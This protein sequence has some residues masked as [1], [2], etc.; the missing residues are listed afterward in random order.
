MI[1]EKPVDE[2]EL[3]LQQQLKKFENNN[4]VLMDEGEAK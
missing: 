3:Q 2:A 4:A 1:D